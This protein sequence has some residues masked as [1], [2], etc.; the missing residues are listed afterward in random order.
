MKTAT[1]CETYGACSAGAEWAQGV[2]DDMAVVWDE[3]LKNGLLEWTY[4]VL[5][6]ERVL[7]PKGAHKLAIRLLREIKTP[8]GASVPSILEGTEFE[9]LIDRVEEVIDTGCGLEDVMSKKWLYIT[10]LQKRY[11][12]AER[13]ALS[14]TFFLC[15]ASMNLVLFRLPLASALAFVREE[16]IMEDEKALRNS[17]DVVCIG[18]PDFGPDWSAVRA[19]LQ[20]LRTLPNPF[21]E[22]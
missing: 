19:Q 14:A 3:L 21:K 12:G 16:E 5:E 18:P 20:L 6:Q 22:D 1:F 7:P 11:S 4:W 17:K 13:M 10:S 15:E 9:G 2:S 8:K